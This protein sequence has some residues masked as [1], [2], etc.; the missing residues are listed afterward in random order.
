[1]FLASEGVTRR[2]IYFKESVHSKDLSQC[3]LL[4]LVLVLLGFSFLNLISAQLHLAKDSLS[5]VMTIISS[6]NLIMITCKVYL[7]GIMAI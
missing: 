4:V 6:K 7:S 5:C 1:M 2:Q 3:T